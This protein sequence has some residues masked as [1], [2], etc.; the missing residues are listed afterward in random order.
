M[1]IIHRHSPF[2]GNIEWIELD[3]KK[4]YIKT[5]KVRSEY[6]EVV[7]I[8]FYP[9]DTKSDI[10]DPTRFKSIALYPPRVTIKVL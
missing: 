10:M 9:P 7:E 1:T 2:E 8:T 4:E 3:E 6:N 5:I